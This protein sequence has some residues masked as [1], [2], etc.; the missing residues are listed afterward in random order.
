MERKVSYLWKEPDAIDS[1][2]TAVSLH[3]HTGHSRESLKF[4]SDHG[5]QVGI[6]RWAL[7]GEERRATREGGV[8]VDFE[9][10][11]WIPPLSPRAAYEVEARQI[12]EQLHLESLVSLT[13]H[14]NIEAPILL[15]TLQDAERIPISMEWTVPD[16]NNELHLGI[17]NLPPTIARALV[18]ELND[19]TGN[20]SKVRLRQLLAELDQLREVLVVLNHPMWD[21]CAVGE[22]QHRQSVSGFMAAF[23]QYV[24]ALE[25]GGLRPRNE[26]QRTADFACGWNVPVIAGGD[27]HGL[28]PSACLNLTNAA[29]FAEFAHEVRQGRSHVLF[30]PQYAEPLAIRI[31]RV[32]NDAVRHY[33]S[34]PYGSTWE[35]RVY[36]SDRNGV[37]RPLCELWKKSPCYI[38]AALAVLRL[39]ETR[40]MV[41]L[42]QSLDRPGQQFRLRWIGEVSL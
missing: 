31:I 23:G 29:S 11:Y 36:H 32:V 39:L 19:Y 22:M 38:G 30:M 5:E 3:G 24:H 42:A 21:L 16:D 25:L 26:N 28:E 2:Q 10:G 40:P 17:H 18:A 1:Y 34:N 9:R 35:H 41:R 6:V 27:R 14:D 15:H 7:A 4:I 8:A 20:P 13:D 37:E 33:P 12:A